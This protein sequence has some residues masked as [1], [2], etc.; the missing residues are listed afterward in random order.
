MRTGR[1]SIAILLTVMCMAGA[2]GPAAAQKC[3]ARN[4]FKGLELYSWQDSRGW[5]FAL[6]PGTNR[7][8][9]AAEIKGQACVVDADR[10]AA[11]FAR[12]GD[13]Q[14][15]FWFHRNIAGF[16][17][18]PDDVI[19]KIVVAAKQAGVEMNG[20]PRE[21]DIA[22]PSAL[23]QC[24]LRQGELNQ[25]HAEL[26]RARDES[27]AKTASIE[28][29]SAEL[30]IQLR[31]VQGANQEFVAAHNARAAEHNVRAAEHNKHVASLR[32]RMDALNN[33][34]TAMQSACSDVGLKLPKL[35]PIPGK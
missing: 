34:M 1:I 27:N 22:T 9:P 7:A 10:L 33:D 6:V 29:E 19:E 28:R 35:E 16:A 8:K 18:P 14:M 15:L 23:Q 5:K 32:E 30:A 3:P 12:L 21:S 25:R 2:S 26:T 20:P 31:N 24:K 4:Q 17:Y 11:E 13:R